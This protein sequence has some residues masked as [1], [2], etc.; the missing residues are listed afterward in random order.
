MREYEVSQEGV[1]DR[2]KWRRKIRNV[3][4]T[5]MWD[6]YIAREREREHWLNYK[7]EVSSYS[8]TTLAY[9]TK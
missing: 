2:V 1:D 4:R 9:V 5:T 3:D 8:I 7:Y 6:K